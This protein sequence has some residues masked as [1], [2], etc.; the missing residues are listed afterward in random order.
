M[1]PG[2]PS[3][4]FG[5]RT[6]CQ[7]IVVGSGKEFLKC[8]ITRSPTFARIIGPGIVPKLSRTPGSVRW[9]ATWEQ[10]SHNAEVYGGLL[11]LSEEELAEL[12]EEG[13]I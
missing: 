9:S 6:P 10:G 4:S 5:T 3:I 13:V 2:A 12:R 1:A 11:G 8:T 7:W